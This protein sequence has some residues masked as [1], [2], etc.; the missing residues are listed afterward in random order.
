MKSDSDA[1]EAL[2]IMFDT[3]DNAAYYVGEFFSLVKDKIYEMKE[4][5]WDSLYFGP[6]I[7]YGLLP[8]IIFGSGI[9]IACGLVYSVMFLTNVFR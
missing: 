7:L 5:F 3:I 8:I 1:L 2:K 9:L 6:I 4:S